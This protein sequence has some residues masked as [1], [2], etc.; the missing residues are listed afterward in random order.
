V[1]ENTG[2]IFIIMK[3]LTSITLLCFSITANADIYFCEDET[4]AGADLAGGYLNEDG[5]TNPVHIWV[6]DT[7]KGFRNTVSRNEEYR[8]SCEVERAYVLCK[9]FDSDK[10][11]E[12]YFAIDTNSSTFT[13]TGHKYGAYASARAGTCT[14]A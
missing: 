6:I 1:A 7:S 5:R 2:R 9:R 12:W 13:Y 10:K 3:L 14:K 4:A 8:G 11:G